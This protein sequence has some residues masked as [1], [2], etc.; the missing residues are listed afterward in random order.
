MAEEKKKLTRSKDDRWLA[1]VCGGLGEY[2]GVDGTLVRVLFILFSFVVGGSIL[3][4]IILWIVMPEEA[5]GDVEGDLVEELKAE[6]E[7]PPDEPE[8][9]SFADEPEEE[10]PAEEDTEE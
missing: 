2:F 5:E 6:K 8:V 10:T 9:E 7:S 4:Y 3:I 1:G